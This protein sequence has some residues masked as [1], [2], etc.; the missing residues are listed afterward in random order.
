MRETLHSTI[1]D[2]ELGSEIVAK[3][4]LA[5]A[6]PMASPIIYPKTPEITILTQNTYFILS[7]TISK[8]RRL[9]RTYRL[10]TMYI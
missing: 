10:A 7:Q 5:N 4:Q 3:N 1:T 2:A 9:N 6:S 8:Q